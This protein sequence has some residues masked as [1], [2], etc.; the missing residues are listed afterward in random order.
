MSRIAYI[1]GRYVPQSHAQVSVEDRG[2]LFSDG[3]YDVIPVHGGQLAFADRYLDRLDRSL[4]ELKIAQPMSRAALL[5]IMRE[6]IERNGIR[7]GTVYVQVTRGVAP[8]DHKFPQGIKP[9]LV[10]MARKWKAPS[11]D[12]LATGAA[13]I[14]TRDQRWARR[15]IK[16]ISLI[17]NVLAKQEAAER[18][19]YEAWMI[20]DAGMV[21]E[22]SS[23]SAWIASANGELVTRPNG[24]EI[25]PG[26]TR[27]VVLD[28]ARELGLTLQLRP[29]SRDQAY[30]A[31]EA[32]LT[33]TNNFV[34]PITRIDGR[35]VGEGKP[36]PIAA[37]LRAAYLKA[38]H[39][40]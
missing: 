10:L 29:F 22:G 16:C 32:F 7:Q 18:G 38:A 12:L 25:L 2:Y 3:V 17:A 21:T 35:P 36:G 19:A 40:D 4:G 15:D 1:N 13:I 20:D 39:H 26:V 11:P 24:V 30:A 28:V 33:S 14:T 37:R 27:S 23:T 9:S 5:Q 34:L 31:R 6:L 8:R